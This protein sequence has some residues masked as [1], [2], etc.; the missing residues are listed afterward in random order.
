MFLFPQT[1]CILNFVSCSHHILA[2]A[3]EGVKLLDRHRMV[4]GKDGALGSLMDDIHALEMKTW[5][6]DQFEAKKGLM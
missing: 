2:D 5:T 6:K 3:F 1:F 4:N